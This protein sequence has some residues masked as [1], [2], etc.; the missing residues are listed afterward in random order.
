MSVIQDCY[1]IFDREYA[2]RLQRRSMKNAVEMEIAGNLAF[3]REAVQAGMSGAKIVAGM[4]D[5][6]FLEALSAGMDL[7][8]M[9][10]ASLSIKTFAGIDE[11]K[12][13]TGWST[14]RLIKKAYERIAT[15]K[16]LLATDAGIDFSRK[17]QYLFKLLL[18]IIAH[19]DNRQLVVHNAQH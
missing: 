16:K 8:S 15:Q 6:Q 11:F 17:L 3:I 19:I 9:R 12:K 5:E 13:Y 14:E 18:L 4:E 7:N 1:N 2:K 10:K